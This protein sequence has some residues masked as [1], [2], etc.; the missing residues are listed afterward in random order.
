MK[1][2]VLILAVIP[3]FTDLIVE[4]ICIVLPIAHSRIYIIY[5]YYVIL[6]CVWNLSIYIFFLS[7]L[8][9]TNLP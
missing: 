1:I 7:F 5:M 6:T 3:A 4:H 8:R 2:I 9:V